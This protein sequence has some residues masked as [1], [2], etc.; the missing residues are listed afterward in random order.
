M[1]HG[2]GQLYHHAFMALRKAPEGRNDSGLMHVTQDNDQMPQS[3]PL[4]Q[5]L[6]AT[7]ELSRLVPCIGA[8]VMEGPHER[9]MRKGWGKLDGTAAAADDSYRAHPIQ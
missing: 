1:F 6:E 4:I 3:Q 9:W 2:V 5:F 7:C 8:Q